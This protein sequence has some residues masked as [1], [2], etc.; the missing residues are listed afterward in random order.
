MFGTRRVYEHRPN[1]F[2]KTCS[3]KIQVFLEGPVEP[4]FQFFQVS[5]FVLRYFLRVDGRP[6]LTSQ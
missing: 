4:T 1:T 5:F 2:E 6:Q 3:L